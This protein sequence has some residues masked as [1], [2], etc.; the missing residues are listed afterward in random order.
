MNLSRDGGSE[1]T[2]TLPLSLDGALQ[3]DHCL[4]SAGSSSSVCSPA[5]SPWLFI[6]AASCGVWDVSSL[7]RDQTHAS[8][9]EV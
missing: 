5:P 6:L 1:D 7:S 9:L 8:A 3:D 2:L 4:C